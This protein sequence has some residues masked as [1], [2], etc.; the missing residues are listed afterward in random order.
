M[1]QP[2]DASRSLTALEQD[3]A[4]IAAIEMSQSKWLIA[5]VVPGIERQPLKKINA[6]EEAVLKLLGA[7]KPARRGARSSASSSLMRPDA[8]ASSWHAGCGHAMS[9]LTSSI[10][11]ASRCRA[12][13][14]ARRLIASTLNC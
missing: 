1:S 5:A 10:L 4:I 14:G 11:R 12:N 6:D 13:T 2:F 8:T 7:T 3:S 9:G